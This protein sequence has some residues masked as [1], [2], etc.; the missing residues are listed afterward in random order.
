MA[1]IDSVQILRPDA[2]ETTI[3][4]YLGPVMAKAQSCLDN[5]PEDE[6]WQALAYLYAHM[7]EQTQG[8]R[9]VSE[10][11]RTGASRTYSE[12]TGKG[13]SSSTYGEALRG[14]TGAAQCLVAV[15]D[16]SD[17]FGVSLNPKRCR[18]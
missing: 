10:K 15:V 14:M 5:Y 1:L 12:K 17:R 13:L 7:T 6:Q 4:F 3:D 2:T 11:T 8:G 16:R 18:P 9:I